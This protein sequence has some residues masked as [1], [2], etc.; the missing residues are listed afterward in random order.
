[1]RWIEINSEEHPLKLVIRLMAFLAGAS[2]MR[3]W[4]QEPVVWKLRGK[5]QRM[6]V[7]YIFKES[8]QKLKER[9]GLWLQKDL[10]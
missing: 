5:K 6:R 4:E 8:N 3:S 1:M 10:G 7:D 2:S 9:E